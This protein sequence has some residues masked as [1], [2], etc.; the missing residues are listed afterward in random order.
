MSPI[1]DNSGLTPIGV[2][3]GPARA[4]RAAPKCPPEIPGET[5]RRQHFQTPKRRTKK[6]RKFLSRI[7]LQKTGSGAALFSREFRPNP[8]EILES[9][10]GGGSS[11][12]PLSPIWRHSGPENS[13]QYLLPARRTAQCRLET[14]AEIRV[15]TGSRGPKKAHQK[16]REFLPK[17]PGRQRCQWCQSQQP[18]VVQKDLAG[19]GFAVVAPSEVFRKISQNFSPAGVTSPFMARAIPTDNTSVVPVSGR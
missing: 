11:V 6:E 19:F 14:P 18:F 15:V 10:S 17:I 8:R 4:I 5:P 9:V 12:Y 16:G 7:P 13:N 2:K 1:G 3:I